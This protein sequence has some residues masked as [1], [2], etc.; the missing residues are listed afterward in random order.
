[1]PSIYLEKREF[2]SKTSFCQN[3]FCYFVVIK[4]KRIASDIIETPLATYY[5][6][7][8]TSEW[9]IRLFSGHYIL[10]Y[11]MQ[12]NILSFFQ[13]NQKNELTTVIYY[14]RWLIETALLWKPHTLTPLYRTMQMKNFDFEKNNLFVINTMAFYWQPA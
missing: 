5:K 1:M 8:I 10:Y 12:H 11:F 13:P 6:G 14:K 4:K 9:V 2:W 3:R 7:R